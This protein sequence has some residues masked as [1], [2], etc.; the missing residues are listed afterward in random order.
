MFCDSFFVFILIFLTLSLGMV[1]SAIPR[2][3]P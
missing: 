2:E 3:D 1:G